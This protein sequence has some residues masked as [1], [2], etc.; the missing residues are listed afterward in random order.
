[1]V[2]QT[3]LIRRHTTG[4]RMGF[5]TILGKEI[6]GW[7]NLRTLVTQVALW[8]VLINGLLGIMY[9]ISPVNTGP[10][11]YHPTTGSVGAANPSNLFNAT[12]LFPL[13][14]GLFAIIG[15]VVM[16][17]DT[18]VGEKQNGTAAWVL[19]KPLSRT[20]FI[21]AKV[22]ANAVS[23]GLVI[24]AVQGALAYLIASLAGQPITLL[25]WM[26]GLG[27]LFVYF[28][29]YMTLTLMLG[30]FFN[31]RGAVIGIPL[32]LAFFGQMILGIAPWI[33]N[34]GPWLL[35]IPDASGLSLTGQMMEGNVSGSL[36]PL[37]TTIVWSGVFIAV[38]IWRFSHDEF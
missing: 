36:L 25:S 17:Q 26:A 7:W 4:W 34:I 11:I 2:S 16:M 15:V 27:V 35:I 31:G 37:L 18:L 5:A 8:A 29:F 23:I 33:A 20:S 32:M 14:M 6:K 24:V 10:N 3:P 38:A 9:F 21:L 19:T 22:V 30:T 28:L 1:M 13:L 12:T